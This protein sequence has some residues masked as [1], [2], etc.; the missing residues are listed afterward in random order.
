MEKLIEFIQQNW[1]EIAKAI[2][3]IIAAASIIVKLTPTLK[4]DNWLLPKLKFISKHIA[5]NTKTPSDRPK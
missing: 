5:L 4:D 1:D 3:C 2:A